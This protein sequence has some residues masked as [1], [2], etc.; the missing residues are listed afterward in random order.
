MGFCS[1]CLEYAP[2]N[3]YCVYC[4]RPI[5]GAGVGAGAFL[6]CLFGKRVVGIDYTQ[7]RRRVGSLSRS[8]ARSL[9]VTKS[10][11]VWKKAGPARWDALVSR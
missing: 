5:P 4:A 3:V 2:S 11:D 8:L 10:K 9:L 1:L 7:Q 6:V